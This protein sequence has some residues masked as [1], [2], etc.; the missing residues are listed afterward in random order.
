MGRLVS[1]SLPRGRSCAARRE[2]GSWRLGLGCQQLE[3]VQPITMVHDD[4]AA[5]RGTALI[6]EIAE[7]VATTHERVQVTKNGREHVVPIAADDYKSMEATIELLTHPEAQANVAEGT[8]V[9]SRGDV[10]DEAEVRALLAERKAR[11]AG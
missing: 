8:A 6:S 10:L 1:V 4:A 3:A 2:V 7:E 5:I 11:A 9:V